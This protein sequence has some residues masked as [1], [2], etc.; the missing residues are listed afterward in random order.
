MNFKPYQQATG[1]FSL[2]LKFNFLE[3]GG[4][5]RSRALLK[6]HFVAKIRG[7]V[8]VLVSLCWIVTPQKRISN[9]PFDLFH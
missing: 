8:I 4:I 6:V 7:I 2:A 5:K 3:N 9:T 1:P